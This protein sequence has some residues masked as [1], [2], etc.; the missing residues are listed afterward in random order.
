LSFIEVKRTE[1]P[2]SSRQP[3]ADQGRIAG[4]L[5]EMLLSYVDKGKVHGV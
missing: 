3:D 4:I 2:V 5:Q 1:K